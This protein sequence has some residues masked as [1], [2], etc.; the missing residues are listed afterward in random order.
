M[1]SQKN[2]NKANYNGTNLEMLI[3]VSLLSMGYEEVSPDEFSTDK[4]SAIYARHPIIGETIYNT[5][6]RCDLLL[7]CPKKFPSFLDRRV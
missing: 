2:L 7:F 6:R 4:N 5:I 1:K 3:E